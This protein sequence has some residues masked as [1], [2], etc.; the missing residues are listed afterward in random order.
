[1]HM[2][3]SYKYLTSIQKYCREILSVLTIF[4]LCSCS[5]SSQIVRDEKQSQI[6]KSC[7]GTGQEYFCPKCGKA[8]NVYR[9]NANE[10]NSTAFCTACKNYIIGASRPCRRCKG[11]GLK[12]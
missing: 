6:C 8:W 11:D 4:I 7:N 10:H 5:Y 1:M 9:Q 2:N 12:H 3:N